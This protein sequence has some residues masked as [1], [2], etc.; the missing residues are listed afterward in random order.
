MR[1]IQTTLAAAL[2]IVVVACTFTAPTPDPAQAVHVRN[3]SDRAVVVQV[4]GVLGDDEATAARP[5][6]GEVSVAVTAD[7]YE[8]DGRLVVT[9][10]VGEDGAFDTALKAWTADP[11]DMPGTFRV[12]PIWSSGEL[13]SRLPAFLTV[14]PDLEVTETGIPNTGAPVGCT[15]AW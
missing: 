2:S 7:R 11:G 5:C 4:G 14:A 1:R 6:G 15:P 13:A 9:L 8:E 12:L 10:S 3:D